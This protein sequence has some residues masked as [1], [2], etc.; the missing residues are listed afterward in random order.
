MTKYEIVNIE[1][2]FEK[3]YDDEQKEVYTELVRVTF[4]A[5]MHWKDLEE[6]KKKTN[7]DWAIDL[8]PVKHE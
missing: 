2:I 6:L 5:V 8:E 1:P 3:G 7:E 4:N